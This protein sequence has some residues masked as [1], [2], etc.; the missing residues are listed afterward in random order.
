MPSADVISD[1]DSGI[2]LLP[3]VLGRAKVTQLSTFFGCFA[4]VRFYLHAFVFVD[5]LIQ[6]RYSEAK[7]YIALLQISQQLQEKKHLAILLTHSN[8]FFTMAPI[9]HC[10]RHAQGKVSTLSRA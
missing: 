4:D 1:A 5:I 10:V 8:H 3:I 6:Y 2:I 9:V 7:L